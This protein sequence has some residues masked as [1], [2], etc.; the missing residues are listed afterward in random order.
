MYS[1]R[2]NNVSGLQVLFLD[3]LKAFCSFDTSKDGFFFNTAFN[4][5]VAIGSF[6][7]VQSIGVGFQPKL[8]IGERFKPFFQVFLVFKQVHALIVPDVGFRSQ[9]KPVEVSTS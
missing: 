6:F 1:E 8:L 9:E 5:Q 2:W 7:P 4:G 3:N